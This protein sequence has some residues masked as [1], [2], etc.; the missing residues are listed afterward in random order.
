VNVKVFVDFDG[1]ISLN[2]VGD[3]L[4]AHF[5]DVSDIV[6]D[7]MKGKISVAE[8]YTQCCARISNSLSPELLVAFN[9]EQQIDYAFKDIIALCKSHNIDVHIVSDG[10]DAYIQPIL[11]TGGISD[12]PIHSNLLSQV[13]DEWI[14]EFPG[15]T[16]S[17]NCFCASCKRNVIVNHSADEDVIVYV[18]DGMSD[19]CAVQ[20]ADVVFAK[21]YLSK[22]CS[23]NG[24][25]HHPITNLSQVLAIM[26]SRIAKS[27][28]KQRRRALIARQSAFI[29]E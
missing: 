5:G 9:A 28:F 2:D 16:E 7:L 4:F 12:V 18:G 22:W 23:E 17:C 6:S 26:K 24:I 13:G 10:L 25:P 29:A 15:A 1:T 20:H 27:D 14:P 19:T 21:G 11:Q 3:K 8:Y